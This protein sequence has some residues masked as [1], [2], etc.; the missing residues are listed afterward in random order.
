M[1]TAWTN[2]QVELHGE[3]SLDRMRS[4]HN[5]SCKT[6]W[7]RI[8]YWCFITPV[9]CLVYNTLMDLAPLAKPSAG[10]EA[11]YVLWIRCIFIVI[12]ITYG[13]F[14]QI[15]FLAPRLE[16]TRRDALVTSGVVTGVCLAYDY[17]IAGY[18]P[19]PVPFFFLVATLPFLFATSAMFGVLFGKKLMSDADLRM[20]FYRAMA[21]IIT[22]L[23][24]TVVYPIYIYGFN[25]IPSNYQSPYMALVPLIK[26]A[27]KNLMSKL[28][29]S[30]DDLKPEVLI[31][32]VDTF[33]AL[34]VTLA[35]QKA[36]TVSTSLL[37]MLI[38][39]AQG[40]VSVCDVFNAYRPINRLMKKL[41]K[42]HPLQ[43]KNF[44]EVAIALDQVVA[45]GKLAPDPLPQKCTDG[46]GG[47]VDLASFEGQKLQTKSAIAQP[48]T[49]PVKTRNKI[50]VIPTLANKVAKPTK[51]TSGSGVL[52]AVSSPSQHFLQENFSISRA[53]LSE[54]DC[55]TFLLATRRLLFTV[56][57]II[58]IEYSEVI[59]PV[60]YSAFCGFD[61]HI[62]LVV[63]SWMDSQACTQR[64]STTYPIDNSTR[65]SPTSTSIN[66]APW[67]R[68]CLA[69]PA[70]SS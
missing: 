58:L 61:I 38:D 64:L 9:P 68:A 11:N 33:N 15:G 16:M 2:L 54:K 57:F 24:L 40:C 69:T 7:W 50:Y 62:F 20:S 18:I 28:V 66:S 41:P 39:V 59:I 25:S 46:R 13:I 55:A 47:Q 70:L 45:Q 60:F 35:M 1:I 63:H 53:P 52:P 8:L 12:P 44:M 10:R 51:S 17:T 27:A 31:F 23:S 34:Y 26:L 37:I 48:D 65:L 4:F 43:E 14:E 32:N 22:E 5:Y 29:G 67:S 19:M 49:T 21:V 30:M 42:Y 56:E 6:S 3:Y 36:T